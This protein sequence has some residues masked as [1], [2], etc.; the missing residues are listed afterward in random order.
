MYERYS[1]VDDVTQLQSY[2]IRDIHVHVY[3]YIRER[4]REE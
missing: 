3:M 2:T 1:M 4:E